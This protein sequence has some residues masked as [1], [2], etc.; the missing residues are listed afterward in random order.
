[1]SSSTS[2]G[3]EA[4]NWRTAGES[5]SGRVAATISC[6]ASVIRPTPMTMRP[7]RPTEVV[8]RLMNS[9]TPTKISSGDSH[10]RSKENTT[11]IALVPM[12]APSITASAAAVAISP[13]PTKDAT[14]SPVAVLDCTSVVTAKPASSAWKRLPTLREMTWR[15]LA[16][17]QA[18][19]AGAH[20][21]RGPDEQRDGRQQVQQ[22]LHGRP[23]RQGPPHGRGQRAARPAGNR[24]GLLGQL[25]SSGLIGH[26]RPR[27]VNNLQ[28]WRFSG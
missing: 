7:K 21:V 17:I 23:P 24:Q 28:P 8:S 11:T 9:T 1:M 20:D 16:P 5:I 25:R 27:N 13:R 22:V 14:I 3:N 6:N 12:S 2:L 4:S 18:Q 26:R 19:H 10:D 15:R